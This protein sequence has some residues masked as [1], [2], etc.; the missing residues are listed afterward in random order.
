MFVQ[1]VGSTPAVTKLAGAH[2]QQLS[3][4]QAFDYATYHDISVVVVNL[5]ASGLPFAREFRTI[6]P[7]TAMI[8]I[9][10]NATSRA[11]ATRFGAIVARND[12]TSAQIA[13]LIAR[14]LKR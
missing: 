4:A 13:S 5:D 12:A 2:S 3:S 10:N 1:G 6:F 9:S 8:A 11:A 14:G 7:E